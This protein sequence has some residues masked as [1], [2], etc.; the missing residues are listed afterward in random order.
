MG[1]R[2]EALVAAVQS[3]STASI[4]AA[5][6]TPHKAS[7][8]IGGCLLI[9]QRKIHKKIPLVRNESGSI[10]IKTIVSSSTQT[11]LHQGL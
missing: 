3:Q 1:E 8:S 10:A 4:D 5:P 7:C 2:G 9:S 11:R 6:A